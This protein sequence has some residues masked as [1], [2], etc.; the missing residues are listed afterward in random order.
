LLLNVF[1]Y[2][3]VSLAMEAMGDITAPA[4]VSRVNDVRGLEFANL[5]LGS[6]V[7]F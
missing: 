6:R 7:E 2:V 4:E 3:T 5:T 1:K